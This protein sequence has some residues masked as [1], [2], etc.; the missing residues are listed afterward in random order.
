VLACKRLTAVRA[1]GTASWNACR[2]A[3]NRA[4]RRRVVGAVG[5]ERLNGAP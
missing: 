2:C 3:W 4:S 1:S 5:Q